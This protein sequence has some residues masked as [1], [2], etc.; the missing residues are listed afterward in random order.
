[1][2]KI[3]GLPLFIWQNIRRSTNDQ[4]LRFYVILVANL[5]NAQKM[6]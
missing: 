2:C 1:M 3:V 6:Y 4:A 5:C